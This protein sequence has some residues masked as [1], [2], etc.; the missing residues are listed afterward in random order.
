M[1]W[2]DRDRVAFPFCDRARPCEIAFLFTCSRFGAR[3]RGPELG[4]EVGLEGFEARGD[5]FGGW[6]FGGD[7]VGGLEAVAGDAHDRGFVRLDAIL[8]DEFLRDS[9]GYAASG[10]GENA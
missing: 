3:C 9:R 2:S 4:V 10:F 8:R 7:G 6:E 5:G 1:V